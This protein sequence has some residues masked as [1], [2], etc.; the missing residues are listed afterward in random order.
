MTTEKKI[1]EIPLKLIKE[2]PE[3]DRIDIS[4]DRIRGLAESISEVGLLQN[5]LV[6]E[7]EGMF[8]IIA[9]HRRILA[10]QSLEREVIECVVCV[11]TDLEAAE[12]RGT[13][14][15]QRVDLTIIE[16]A[17]TYERIAIQYDR[18]NQQIGK[19]FGVSPAIVKRRRDLLKMQQCLQDAMHKNQIGYGVA[20]ALAP[21]IDQTALDYYL[22]FAIDHGVT[23][24]IA[25]QWARDWKTSLRRLED[26]SDPTD[27]L[28]SPATAVP[29][30]L[31]CDLCHEPEM[32][33]DFTHLKVCRGCMKQLKR[34]MAAEE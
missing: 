12:A 21:I 2:P 14:N 5:P 6:R 29:T 7:K 25:R 8:E 18:T 9:G 4:D 13:E 3:I 15:L 33:Q 31:A 28:T 10:F 19:R 22:G 27:A 30:Y 11:M 26:G 32:V 17:K 24:T 23:V 34:V 16:E 20:E 1:M